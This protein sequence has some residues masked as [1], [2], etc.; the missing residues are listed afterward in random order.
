MNLFEFVEHHK[1]IDSIFLDALK[2]TFQDYFTKFPELAAIMWT[3]YTP[4]FNDG[5]PCTLTVCNPQFISKSMCWQALEAM[6]HSVPEE[7]RH[8]F[9]GDSPD[10]EQYFPENYIEN[11]VNPFTPAP[12]E[13]TCESYSDLIAD[14]GLSYD[15]IEE[16]TQNLDVTS[17]YYAAERELGKLFDTSVVEYLLGECFDEY[18]ATIYV[19]FDGT[20]VEK[21]YYCGY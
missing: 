7:Y 11:F 21:D 5:D 16:F 8:K 17:D 15:E 12:E 19:F 14:C 18:G 6:G 2:E 13:Y 4:S 3:Q 20:V 1:N 10:P 9:F